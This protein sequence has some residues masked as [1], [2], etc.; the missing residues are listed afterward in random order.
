MKLTMSIKQLLSASKKWNL[1]CL[2]GQGLFDYFASKDSIML[3]GMYDD[4]IK[5]LSMFIHIKRLAH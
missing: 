3:V 4:H 2:I 1:T 5:D